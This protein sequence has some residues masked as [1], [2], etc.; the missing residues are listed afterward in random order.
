[1]EGLGTSL[2]FTKNLPQL[3]I[4]GPGAPLAGRDLPLGMYDFTLQGL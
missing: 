1:M 4:L 3:S 2:H